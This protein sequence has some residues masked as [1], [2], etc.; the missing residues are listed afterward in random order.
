[1]NWLGY[2]R[3]ERLYTA[4]AE[5]C[6]RAACALSQLAIRQ[7]RRLWNAGAWCRTQAARAYHARIEAEEM[8]AAALEEVQRGG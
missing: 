7:H 6:D 2:A 4:A 8:L 3:A 1:M 5:V